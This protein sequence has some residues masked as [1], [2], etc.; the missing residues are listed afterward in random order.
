MWLVRLTTVGLSVCAA[1]WMR[2]SFAVCQGVGDGDLQVAGEVLLA[3]RAEAREADGGRLVWPITWAVQSLLI[4]ALQAAVEGVGGV[5]D[6]ELIGLAV[7]GETAL[8]DAV[9][10][11]ADEGAEI[12]GLVEVRLDG[13]EAEGHIGELPAFD[14][15]RAA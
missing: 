3:V 13:A 12:G 5:V 10:V 2:S 9:A 15:A 4:E 14:P 6:R 1:Y 8:G 7:E 11:P